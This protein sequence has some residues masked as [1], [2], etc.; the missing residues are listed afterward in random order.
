M[1]KVRLALGLTILL[2]PSVVH[3]LVPP[4]P[5]GHSQLRLVRVSARKGGSKQ[6]V[7]LF[8]NQSKSECSA[9]VW[10]DVPA[11]MELLEMRG[12][13]KA[14]KVE[15]LPGGRVVITVMNVKPHGSVRVAF[16]FRPGAKK[17]TLTFS[18]YAHQLSELSPED[19]EV[20]VRV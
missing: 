15:R 10:V 1:M 16:V 13:S 18:G 6:V 7:L 4:P 17:Q 8:R 5:G 19:N 2:Y 11:D 12:S 20:R 3:C 14:D 9:A